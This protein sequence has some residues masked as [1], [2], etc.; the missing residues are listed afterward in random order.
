MKFFLSLLALVLLP[1]QDRP[2]KNSSEVVD[3]LRLIDPVKDA[4]R[5]NWKKT[6]TG[7]V[8]PGRS[9][10]RIV[11]PYVPP[12][13]YDVTLVA[14]RHGTSNSINLG[15]ALGDVQFMVILDAYINSVYTS[16]L[17]LIDGKG[18]YGNETTTRK[19]LF[20]TG[21][22][23]T[24]VCSV[25]K[26]RIA[27]SVDGKGV[28]DWKADYKRLSL[29]SGWAVPHKTC[30]LIGSWT[31]VVRIEKLELRAV[32]GKGKPLNRF[33]PPPV[34]PKTLTEKD[35]RAKIS[36][37][38]DK[39][40]SRSINDRAAADFEIG[41]LPIRFLPVVQEFAR[42]K[43]SAEV[44]FRVGALSVPPPWPKILR[45]SIREAGKTLSLLTGRG[46]DRE[47]AL[48]YA[49]AGLATLPAKD[50]RPILGT[51]LK[52]ENPNFVELA[53]KGYTLHPPEDPV[54]MIELLKRPTTSKGAA[55]VLIA[56]G[57][58]TIRPV[59]IEILKEG[60][61]P[62]ADEAARVLEHLGP[63]KDLSLFLAI[64]EDPKKNLLHPRAL[65]IVGKAG[66][67]EAQEALLAL[68]GENHPLSTAIVGELAA[69]AGEEVLPVI[70]EFYHRNKD[71]SGEDEIRFAFRDPEWARQEFLAAKSDS[72]GKLN[73]VTVPRIAAA[74]G[75]VLRDEVLKWLTDPKTKVSVRKELLPLLGAVGRRE[76]GKLLVETLADSRLA[77]AAAQG[78]D[79]LGDPALVKPIM[80]AFIRT[81]YSLNLRSAILS[82]PAETLEDD[83]AELISDPGG[84][85][86]KSPLAIRVA[87]RRLTPRLR[88]ILFEGVIEGGIGWTSTRGEALRVL[89]GTMK[90]EDLPALA[91]LRAHAK[92]TE[93]ATGLLLAVLGGD[94]EAPQELAGLLS[95]GEYILI[96]YRGDAREL[97]PVRLMDWAA[98]AGKPWREAVKAQWKAK[99][100]WM[101]GSIWLAGEGDPEVLAFVRS[102]ISLYSEPL[103]RHLFAKLCKKGD[104]LG[105]DG[106][107]DRAIARRPFTLE[108]EDLFVKGADPQTRAR[109]IALAR[110]KRYTRDA[111]IIRLAA[112]LADPRA[113]EF[114]RQLLLSERSSPASYSRGST[115]TPAALRALG[116]LKAP[117]AERLA[118]RFLRSTVARDRAAA[119]TTLAMLGDRKAVPYLIRLVDDPFQIQPVH[120][121]SRDTKPVRRVWHAAMDAL[122]TLT[123]VKPEG[124]SIADRREFWR[125]WYAKSGK[126]WK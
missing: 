76:D 88:K 19:P 17:E 15:L 12:E 112:L 41:S 47:T 24:V 14:E 108:E 38:I 4:V 57:K 49:L 33:I 54:S 86:L 123:N 2:E 119:A 115:T 31:S 32:T 1:P 56:T 99:P 53:L 94:P 13:E 46:P 9:F 90:K 71:S 70:R 44:T 52:S 107:I 121:Q 22:P 78:L 7:L 109:V 51:F 63:G 18:F 73:L 69:F 16:G 21:K 81:D 42:K 10:T 35:L 95:R 84:Y 100:G 30:L 111:P 11:V 82:L 58:E 74:G 36:A 114:Y 62:P 117:G 25:R 26:N 34:L 40:D 92:P 98:P 3:L 5:G 110:S 68:L 43:E 27:V 8:S 6:P 103:K 29:F 124:V 104:P 59:L 106:M 55:D 96:P 66:T 87:E 101:E 93:Q 80:G 60:K 39:L 65:S 77:D 61:K 79:M 20:T 89:A 75:P 126:D 125:S 64:L 120:Y 102:R 105:L 122:E 67:P 50:A 116:T 45:G 48:G 85:S 83:L 28:I 113:V 118:R 37:L 91:G 97:G 72:G 23:H